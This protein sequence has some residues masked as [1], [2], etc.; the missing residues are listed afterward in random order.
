MPTTAPFKTPATEAAFRAAYAAT[1][2][3][4]PVPSTP[5]DVQTSFGVT[6]LNAAGAP[7]PSRR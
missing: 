4:W 1:L 6:H 3:L 2:A 5:L 7:R